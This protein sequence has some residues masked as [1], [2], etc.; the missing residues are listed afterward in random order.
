[1]NEPRPELVELNR[2]MRDLFWVVVDALRIEQII[3]WLD[4]KLNRHAK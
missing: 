1:M 3:D 4:N 2:A